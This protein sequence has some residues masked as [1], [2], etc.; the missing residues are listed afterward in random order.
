MFVIAYSLLFQPFWRWPVQNLY[1]LEIALDNR[2]DL[3]IFTDF[4]LAAPRQVQTVTPLMK[5]ESCVSIEIA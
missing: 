2:S 5:H 1:L 4:H 3:A